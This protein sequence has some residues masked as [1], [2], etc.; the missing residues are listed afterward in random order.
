MAQADDDFDWTTAV[1]VED[2]TSSTL[3]ATPF[4]ARTQP[5]PTQGPGDGSLRV[6]MS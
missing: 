4:G 2:E 6:P 5:Q 3:A 1:P